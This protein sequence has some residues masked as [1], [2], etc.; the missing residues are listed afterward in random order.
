M[1]VVGERADSL[2]R[3]PG[4]GTVIKKQDLE[5][6]QPV[7][8][9]EMLRR[10]PGVQV[11]Q[12]Y[13]AGSRLDVSIR[14]IDGGRSR[15]VLML[16]DGVPISINPYSEPDIYHT[17]VI[18]RYRAIE[19][20]K[21]SGNILFG[22]QTLA[23]TINFVTLA[24]PDRRTVAFDYDNGTYGYA[25]ALGMYGDRVGETA[26]VVQLVHRRGDGFRGLP[27]ESTNGLAKLRFETNDGGTATIKLGFHRDDTG[28]DDVGL[29][30]GMYAR[31]PRRVT[32]S[33]NSQLVL[34]RYDASLVHEQRIGDKT[35]LKTLLYG[36]RTDRIWRRQEYSRTGAPGESYERIVGDVRTP[37]GAIFFKNTTAV[38]DRQYDVL[39]VEPRLEH[40]TTT[41]SVSHTLDFGG[42]LLRET[43]HY[44]TRQGTFPQSNAGSLDFE[45]NHSGTAIAAYLQDRMA[46][47]PDLLVTPGVRFE[48]LDFSRV[49]TRTDQGSGPTDVRQ[50]GSRNVTGVIPGVGMIYGTK[51]THVF[52]GMHLG[53]APPRVTS[54]I[55]PRGLATE[56]KSD[57]SMSYELG[58]R[59]SPLKWT[60]VE[61]TGFLSNFN[62]QV[63]VNTQPGA[64]TNLVDAGATRIFGVESG[65]RFELGRALALGAVLDLGARYTYSRATFRYG[66]TAGNLLPY[67]PLHSLNTNVDVEH[68]SGLGGQ[69]AYALIGKQYTDAL[70]TEDEDVTG[71][72][73]A[74]GARHIVDATVHYR[75]KPSGISL[76]LT[77]KNLLD[78]TYIAARR[79]EGIFTGPYRQIL[80]GLRWEY[81]AKPDSGNLAAR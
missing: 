35:K 6:A 5:R 1:R 66:A 8:A 76:R 62:N 10:V 27:F 67:A 80:V 43:A 26:W 29:T 50:E 77:A 7:D 73:G 12:D 60:R 19:V 74:L 34:N 56:V 79:P 58:T 21:G 11:R 16:E 64:D 15:R 13:A 63:I 72:V 9:S 4:S 42:R 18:E 57:E 22:P 39:G 23:G 3:L 53:F 40:R 70:N 30:R 2:Q 48:H 49:V 36:Y 61:V 45:E 25:R 24:P 33:P 69:I 37:D 17:P 78:Q 46:F 31:D 41:G 54:A 38:L 75:H 68:K 47:R 14:G 51:Q 59:T 32:L 81:E 71:R 65:T 44:Q 55:N 28:A 20:V 52:G